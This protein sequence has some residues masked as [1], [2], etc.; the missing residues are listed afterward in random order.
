MRLNFNLNVT[1]DATLRVLMDAR[2]GDYIN[3]HGQGHIL[4][5]YYNKGRFSMYGTYHVEDGIYKLSL[6]D[7]IRK[8]FQ[9][10][11]G[12]AI[13]FGGN[14]QQASLNLKATYT[15]PN[16]SMDDLSATTLGLSNTRVDCVMNIGGRPLAPVVTFDFDLPQANEDEKNMVRQMIN[17]EEE[18]NMQVIY[19]LGIGRFY[20][21]SM[22][23][24]SAADQSKTAMN[25]LLSS[26]L[27]NQFNQIMSNML[28]T[29]NW[30]FGAN[31]RT[32][33]T[34]WD[35]TDEQL[36][37]RLRR[38]LPAHPLGECRPESIQPDQRPLLHPVVTH[39]TGHRTAV[40][41]RLQPVAR[42]VAQ[43]ETQETRHHSPALTLHARVHN[44]Y[45]TTDYEEQNATF[46]H[47]PR[48]TRLGHILPTGN[49]GAQGNL[50]QR[51]ARQDSRRMGRTTHRMHLWRPHRVPL[52][53]RTHP[54]QC[55]HQLESRLRQVVL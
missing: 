7:V 42:A 31:L 11:S 22:Q 32:G 1:P 23:Y 45:N 54:R 34:G 4:A 41:E 18:R 55:G 19:L 12:S 52:P 24:V 40:Q 49:A 50:S 36:H 30:S 27:S 43:E 8:D 26:T 14:A 16:V 3:L 15:V 35:Q 2:S 9:F 28:G 6:Q 47:A 53:R 37:R 21:Q 17:T 33:E 38:A 46:S 25:S 10:Q 48:H 13:T 20:N 44:N 5:N 51:T 29:N 39:H